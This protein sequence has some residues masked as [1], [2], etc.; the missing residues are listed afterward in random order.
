[1]SDQHAALI[2][3]AIVAS[4]IPREDIERAV[5]ITTKAVQA[6]IA[7]LAAITDET[8]NDGRMDILCSSIALNL[9]AQQCEFTFAKIMALGNSLGMPTKTV[10]FEAEIVH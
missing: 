4:R 6:A 3:Q 8:D 7:A 9:V 10:Q 2:R 1:M 5:A